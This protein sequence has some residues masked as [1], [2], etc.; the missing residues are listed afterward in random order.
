MIK[1]VRPGRKLCSTL[2]EVDMLM[3]F[4]KGS[5]K[6][7]I[8]IVMRKPAHAREEQLVSIEKWEKRVA[9]CDLEELEYWWRERK[10][11]RLDNTAAYPAWYNLLVQQ[12]MLKVDGFS[13]KP[14]TIILPYMVDF[15]IVALRAKLVKLLCGKGWPSFAATYYVNNHRISTEACKKTSEILC[16]VNMPWKPNKCKCNE[17]LDG[18][19]KSSPHWAPPI[20]N[21]HIF[22]IGREY[23][24]PHQEVMCQPCVNIPLPTRWDMKRL[25]EVARQPFL[26]NVSKTEWEKIL[27]TCWRHKDT[28]SSFYSTREVYSTSE[29]EADLGSEKLKRVLSDSTTP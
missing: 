5:F 25:W 16:N 24:G 1:I 20:I 7:F 19:K 2:R 6:L 14:A 17:L 8:D 23:Q 9:E 13:V 11:V 21:G 29:I 18:F 26:N 4:N 15:D 10:I 22:M 27:Q 12:I 3:E 28:K